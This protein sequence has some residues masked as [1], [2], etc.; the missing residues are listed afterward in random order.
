MTRIPL[1]WPRAH[2]IALVLLRRAQRIA[3][4]HPCRCHGPCLAIDRACAPKRTIRSVRGETSSEVRG[5]QRQRHAP[6]REFVCRPNDTSKRIGL[7]RIR[8][9]QGSAQARVQVVERALHFGGKLLGPLF[10]LQQ[11]RSIY[12]MNHAVQRL[13]RRGL[14]PRAQQLSSVA[15]SARGDGCTTNAW[16]GRT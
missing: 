16:R 1:S 13:N 12:T 4:Q 8:V 9:A 7:V 6:Q 15:C 11:K 2:H 14:R 5:S 3:Q 10:L